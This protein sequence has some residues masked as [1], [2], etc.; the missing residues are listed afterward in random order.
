LLVLEGGPNTVAT[1][2]A[3]I[4][5]D[6]AV[7]VVIIKDSG[8]AADLLAFAH[9]I[10]H[11]EG[12]LYDIGDV[13]EHK[14]LFKRIEQT[15]PELDYSGCLKVYGNILKCVEKKHLITIFKMEEGAADLDQ[16]ILTALLKSKSTSQ[17]DQLR[18]ALIWNRP[19]IARAQI[20]SEDHKWPL[21]SLESAMKSALDKGR[22][23][24]VE[25][26]LEHGVNMAKFL[27]LDRLESLYNIRAWKRSSILQYLLRA[28]S[29]DSRSIRI[30]DIR[31][32]FRQLT[33]LSL[34]QS[35]EKHVVST[36]IPLGER[37][38]TAEAFQYPFNEL[39]VWAVL[40]NMQKMALCFWK[41]GGEA[42][43]KAL[44][45]CK[46]YL[47]M[48]KYGDKRQL[49]DDIVDA[50]RLN[51]EEFQRL[52]VQ[53]LDV[54]FITD[55]SRASKLLTYELKNWGQT[56]NL[57]LAV[58]S[59]HIQFVAHSCN[60]EL[61]TDIWSGIMTFKTQKSLKV[62]LCLLPPLFLCLGY[63]TRKELREMPQTENYGILDG[64]E[65]E[66]EEE[67]SDVEM[68]EEHNHHSTPRVEV[69]MAY[70]RSF[71]ASS[72]M[73]ILAESQ[74]DVE[75]NASSEIKTFPLKWWEKFLG[76]YRAPITKFWGNVLSYLVFLV[77]FTYV[78]MGKF[79]TTPSAQ[80]IIV[81]IFVISLTTEEIRQILKSDSGSFRKKV[82]E[83]SRSKWNL[84]DGL[85]IILF[86]IGLILRLNQSTLTAGRVVLALDI[87]LWIIRLLDIFS[88]NQNLGPYVVIIGKM[89]IDL[90]YFLFIMAVFLLAYG[91][92][93]QT[94]LE[95][96]TPFKWN[97]VAEIFF[98]PYFQVYGE[99]FIE[100]DLLFSANSTYFG[101]KKHSNV[102]EPVVS[103]LMAFYLLIA[104]ILLLNLLIAI[105]N[106]T[107]AK[108]QANS[109][110]IWKFQRYHL[111]LEYA[112]RPPL[113]PPFVIINHIISI[114]R[115]LYEK[116]RRFKCCG[117]HEKKAKQKS[118]KKIKFHP[119]TSELDE[120]LQYEEGC[121][122]ELLRK[123]EDHISSSKNA[124][125]RFMLE[126]IENVSWKLEET[127]KDTAKREE[128]IDT[129]LFHLQHKVEQ[130]TKSVTE[131]VA[132]LSL[133]SNSD[134][135]SVVPPGVSIDQLTERGQ[136]FNEYRGRGTSDVGKPSYASRPAPRRFLSQNPYMHM[137]VYE[138]NA[139][140]KEAAWGF[141]RSSLRSPQPSREDLMKAFANQKNFDGEDAVDGP[142]HQTEQMTHD[143][144]NDDGVLLRRRT[145]SCPSRSSFE[146][147]DAKNGTSE[148]NSREFHSPALSEVDENEIDID[149]VDAPSD[150]LDGF[151][152]IE[153]VPA[154][155]LT[156]PIESRKSPYPASGVIRFSV[157]DSCV[158]W[159]IDY[160]TYNP[161]EYTSQMLQLS[162]WID[163][164]DPSELKF[165]A[166]DDKK[167]NRISH[168]CQ[169]DVINN[170][171]RNPFGRTGITGRGLLGRWGPNHA[172]E[173]VI[174]RWKRKPSNE[175]FERGKFSLEFLAQQK[176]DDILFPGGMI[177]SL[178]QVPKVISQIFAL[179]E[180]NENRKIDA[181]LAGGFEVSIEFD[182]S[183]NTD[184]S[185]LET[186]V[187]NF[188][189]DDGSITK[190]L[191]L[192]KFNLSWIEV[193]SDLHMSPKRKEYLAKVAKERG[194]HF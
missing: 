194:A 180:G 54:C 68:E 34:S 102:S 138:K 8:R 16:A 1:V 112:R 40:N 175:K 104:N 123:E 89:T 129:R 71:D 95:P 148:R 160:P 85:A 87:M 99:L 94:L 181:L 33:G 191:N 37:S 164:E 188:H 173:A 113:V 147:E 51:G 20:F 39:F 167:V 53:L 28:D 25:L 134:T 80:E 59:D 183:R 96:N 109:N 14:L 142:P 162:S 127:K 163:G 165:N 50:L 179:Q 78:L 63:R 42:M 23:E 57:G 74:R 137:P 43:A 154:F 169:Y 15:Y 38:I 114:V 128:G 125:L 76:F 146:Q 82:Y 4:S 149:E 177:L 158:G 32:V 156:L 110:E 60:Q 86:Y 122:A 69:N 64:M 139:K 153:D 103:L 75:T 152:A 62:V 186:K 145:V 106:N 135:Q 93:R 192:S 100:K 41:R 92:A 150:N 178:E 45:A 84:C 21:S 187:V 143:S 97:S 66:E 111:I 5:Q 124:K 159:I 36:T 130:L 10:S 172:M 141:R 67:T 105:F 117:D 17:E 18:L 31:D 115:H 98:V 116:C 26:L 73:S 22:T 72:Q 61:L 27:T 171:P 144:T 182:D 132:A 49:K 161:V 12:P 108:V 55:E 157:P 6:P 35:Q 155:P 174:T 170:R 9:N 91:V 19:D 168:F 185:W 119:N 184:N 81:I 140:V 46:L 24:F 48:A 47:Q 190:N 121:L 13:A 30:A 118:D 44:V 166:I 133:R 3:A 126:R 120:L 189:D 131:A 83:W 176:K 56:T 88:V 90:A 11:G 193:D 58:S 79:Q 2:H 77:L 65:E 52:A 151:N 7:P 70:S 29:R 136:S 107:F 101:T